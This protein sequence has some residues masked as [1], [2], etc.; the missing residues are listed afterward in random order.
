MSGRLWVMCSCH[1]PHS[2]LA[3]CPVGTSLSLPSSPG[4]SWQLPAWSR[5]HRNHC[6]GVLP[7]ATCSLPGPH[8]WR[9]KEASVKSK[10]E[11]QHGGSGTGRLTAAHLSSALAHAQHWAASLQAIPSLHPRIISVLNGASCRLHEITL[12]KMSMLY[13]GEIFCDLPHDSLMILKSVLKTFELCLN[14]GKKK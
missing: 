8:I 6:H 10:Q 9:Q 1:C 11:A 12:K 2:T 3:S 7:S 4:G 13:N 5:N 14:F